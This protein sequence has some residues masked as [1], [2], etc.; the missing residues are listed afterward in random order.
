MTGATDELYDCIIIGAGS[1]GCGLANRL[2]SQRHQRP[3]APHGS[4]QDEV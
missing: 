3:N 4:V 1:T 2:D